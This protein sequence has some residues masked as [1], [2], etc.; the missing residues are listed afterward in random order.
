VKAILLAAGFGK[1]LG[2][3][4]EHIP[5]P[6]VEVKG[7][8]VIEHLIQKLINLNV[9]HIYI[10]THY[11]HSVIN[12]FISKSNFSIPITLIHEN[13]LLGTASTL[14]SLINEVA[15]EDFIV[16]HADNFFEDTLANLKEKHLESNSDILVTIGAIK[17]LDPSKFGTMELSSN[18][19]VVNFFE[20][21]KKSTSHIG[22]SAIYIMK[23][24]VKKIIEELTEKENDISLHL[25][26][27]LINKIKAEPLSGYF[28]DIGTP[29]DLILANN[30]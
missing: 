22:N 26:P 7:K 21:D 24:E 23:P 19:T 16:M 18:S 27:K 8:P 25:I 13:K 20:K 30:S 29:E 12:D 9:E 28:Y 1:R 4:T 3:I 17:V 6:L 11:K 2:K 15:S 14:K 10:N 5:K